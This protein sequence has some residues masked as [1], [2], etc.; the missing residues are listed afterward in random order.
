L[1]KHRI[2]DPFDLGPDPGEQHNLATDPAYADDL[3][4]LRAK[5]D[6]LPAPRQQDAQ[7]R[8]IP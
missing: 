1:D 3:A 6:A 2:K 8:F 5:L 4:R 7:N